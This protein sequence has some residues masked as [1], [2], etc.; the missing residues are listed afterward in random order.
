MSDIEN[1]IQYAMAAKGSVET[2]EA[3]FG[4]VQERAPQAMSG[5]AILGQIL[6]ARE[7]ILKRF[8]ESDNLM[9]GVH[10]ARSGL[11]SAQGQ[12][13]V[14]DLQRPAGPLQA[15]GLNGMAAAEAFQSADAHLRHEVL[16]HIQA[17]IEAIGAYDGI[18]ARGIGNVDAARGACLSA[19]QAI[20]EEAARLRDAEGGP[21]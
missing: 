12:L 5:Q 1:A 2:T 8:E 19:G 13:Q 15:A 7:A 10:A 17:A 6:M 16:P 11:R 21:Y 18:V 9:L 3:V 14:A 4:D 20:D